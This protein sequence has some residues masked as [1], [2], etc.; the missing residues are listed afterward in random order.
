MT[1]PCQFVLLKLSRST[2]IVVR[3]GLGGDACA[4]L[5]IA[6]GGRLA[7]LFRGWLVGLGVLGLVGL[8]GL[9][10]LL[11]DLLVAGNVRQPLDN[12]F[13]LGLIDR[14]G[15][16]HLPTVMLRDGRKLQATG[17]LVV[18]LIVSHALLE[19]SEPPE[20]VMTTD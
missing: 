14:T 16:M 3:L 18:V 11:L 15:G 19:G 7:S 17:R 9:F 4:N 2:R 13:G 1:K 12:L 20:R 6:V 10:G 8:R 5:G